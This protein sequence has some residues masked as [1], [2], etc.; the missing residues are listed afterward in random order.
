[1][2][3]LVAG[4]SGFVGKNLCRELRRRGH[5][6]TALSRSPGDDDLPDGVA[7]AMGN[8]TAYDSIAEHFAGMDAVVNL[9]ALSPLFKPSGGYQRHFEVHLRGTEN[10]VRA[11][12]EHDVD[13]FVQMSGHP[14]GPDVQTSYHR[15]KA[16]GEEVVRDSSLDWT[17]FR[18]SVIFGDDAEFLRFT[19]LLA[20]PYLT[21]LPG[22]GKTPFQPIWIGD[23]ASMMADAVDCEDD[24]HVGETYTLGGPEVLTLAEVARLAHGADGRSV[25]VIPIPMALTGIGLSIVGYVPGV[26]F[27]EEQYRS[28]KLDST[29]PDNDVSAFGV[30][31]SDLRSLSAYLSETEA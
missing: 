26:P 11:A 12:E 17:I 30:E 19:K 13:R 23:L 15:A 28:L 29:T 9:V 6:V 31:E 5:S 18:P 22:G 10:C 20:P 3:I 25:T 2:K 14:V 27:G 16:E 7:K 24:R 8:V 4:G 1:M 21:P